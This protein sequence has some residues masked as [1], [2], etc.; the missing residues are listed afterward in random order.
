MVTLN[1][2]FFLF[3]IIELHTYK[4]LLLNKTYFGLDNISN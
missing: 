1:K 3:M 2:N 4:L